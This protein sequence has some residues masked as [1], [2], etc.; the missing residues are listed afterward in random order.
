MFVEKRSNA[1]HHDT[2]YRKAERIM[3]NGREFAQLVFDEKGTAAIE[4]GLVGTFLSLLM[5]GLVDFGMGY[6]E[7]MQV[8]NAARA[9]AEYAIANASALSTPTTWTSSEIQLIQ[10]AVTGATSLGSITASPPPTQSCGC[11]TASG[12]ITMSGT[13]PALRFARAAGRPGPMPPSMRR[14]SIRPSCP[15]PELSSHRI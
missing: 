6:W 12:G 9:G 2:A 15:I 1:R 5:I 10:N 3:K 13:P 7:Q 14:R 8:G 4:F 11:P